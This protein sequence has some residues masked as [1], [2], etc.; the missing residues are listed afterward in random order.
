[1]TEIAGSVITPQIVVT[2]GGPLHEPQELALRTSD[3][4]VRR[5]ERRYEVTVGTLEHAV[6]A[7]SAGTP[8]L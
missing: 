4:L 7:T 5:I 2:S 6:D 1:V 3:V 8:R